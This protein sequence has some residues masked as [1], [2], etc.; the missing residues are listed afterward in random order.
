VQ[1]VICLIGIGI[2]FL[3]GGDMELIMSNILQAPRGTMDVLP[4][5]AGKWLYVENAARDTAG[6]FGF[7]EIRFP[8]FEYTEL[9]SRG[10]GE[11]TDVVQKEMYTFAD[12]G[13]RSITLRPEGTASTVRALLQNGLHNEPMPLKLFYLTS[14]FRG[15]RPQAGRL[16]EF[17][18]FG[19]E[20]FGAAAP[21]ADVEAIMLARSFF[22]S[23]GITGLALEINSIGCPECRKKYQQALH[24]YFTEHKSNLCETCQGRL[25][26]NPMRIL[27][28]K[29]PE[30]GKIAALAP[31]V[32][33]YICDDCRTHFTQVQEQLNALGV[34]FT[35]NPSIVRG[36]DYY[37]RTVFEFIDKKQGLTLCGGGRYDGLISEL[38]GADLPALGF[39]IGLERLLM[40]METQG[41]LFPD[42]DS[43]SIYLA[44]IGD[45]ASKK[46]AELVA[47]LRDEGFTAEYDIIGRS[48]KAQMKYADKRGFDYSI[49]IGDS[50]LEKNSATIKGLRNGE[51]HEV[52]LDENLI[53]AVYDATKDNTFMEL[54][55]AVE[56]GIN[57]SKK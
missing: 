19:V 17:H 57:V 5:Q 1:N 45:A 29:S 55:N 15:E 25:E 20:F 44:P 46:A 2:R 23:L 47:L 11:T 39:A 6:L 36:L 43:T 56:D 35:V 37:T 16:R 9:F 22:A 12:R 13:G 40:V 32:T 51:T 50:E 18:Q 26:S 14:C 53:A 48:I 52:P 30:C 31:K 28:C 3:I 8:T 34:E 4:S 10:V 21:A 7:S 54:E 41:C 38:G 49:V 24:E 27:D 33:D 42:E